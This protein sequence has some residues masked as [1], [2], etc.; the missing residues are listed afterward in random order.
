MQPIAGPTLAAAQQ[1]H[2]AGRLDDADRL[3]RAVLAADPDHSPTRFLLGLTLHARGRLAE[4]AEAFAAVAA[5]DPGHAESRFMLGLIDQ[6][7]RHLPAAVDH[8]RAT[9]AI[10]PGHARAANNL[11]RALLDGGDVA[12]GLA[13]LR[14]VVARH[15]NHAG[16]H[17]NLADALR[18]SGDRRAAMA[19]YERAVAVDPTSAPAHAGL[20]AAVAEVGRLADAADLLRHA[21][22]LDPRSATAHY[23]LARVLQD[24]AH[25]DGAAAHAARAIELRPDHADAWRT[26]G[27]LHGLAGDVPA[28]IA[29]QRR[30]LDLRPDLPGGHSNLLLSL[31]YLPDVPPAAVAD[32]HRDWARR[33]ADPLSIATAADAQTPRMYIRGSDRPLRIG[34]VSADFRTHPVAT[35]IRPLLAAHDPAAVDVTC[36]A[37]VVRP[38]AT[39]ERLRAS[40]PRW[41]DIAPLADAAAAD[42]IRRDDIDVLVDLGGHTAG[43]RLGV[44]ARRPAPVQASYL[45]YPATTGMAAMD[46]RLTDAVADPPGATEPFHT[47]RLARLAGGAWAYAPPA[48]GPAVSPP[49]S[50]ASGFVTFGS[51]NNLPKLTPAVLATWAAILAAVPGSRLVLKAIGLAGATGRA[52]VGRHLTGVDPA[53]VDLLPW[54]QDAA[55]HLHLYGRVDVALDPFPYNGTTTT[56]ESVWTGVPVVTLAGRS[57]AGRVGASLLTHAGLGE[58][59][60]DTADGY[61]RLAVDLAADAG[62]R[63]DLRRSLR[64]RLLASPVGDVAR[65]A[66]AVERAYLLM[67]DG[68]PH[69]AWRSPTE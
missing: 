69:P 62:R 16:G 51:F 20:G 32:A 44:F 45:G 64:P 13:V 49:P 19:A 12:A 29:A 66:R 14:D 11:G 4:A 43:N 47:E 61:V 53:R 15:P 56:C 26:V 60:A 65:L 41:R 2:R 40:V 52:Y 30:A 63:V 31:N 18:L 33:S 35:F 57:H 34:Y 5:A 42:L 21:V 36:Y 9:L 67:V 55:S 58:L 54:T 68:R 8:Y 7:Q 6:Q 22:A 38:D 28:A 17:L 46:Y 10:D 3:Y 23:N 1:A 50:I 37:S 27:N 39:T 48:A 24:L 25:L 59:V